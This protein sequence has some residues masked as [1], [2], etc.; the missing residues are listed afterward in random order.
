MKKKN[1]YIISGCNGAGKT[2]ASFTI[3]PEILECKEFVNAD[4]IAKGLSPFQP[5]K[6]AFEAGR[7]MLNRIDELLKSDENF[8]FETTLATKSYKQRI[9][10]AKEQGYTVTLLFFWLNNFELAKE[11]VMIR[12]N[13]GVHNIPPEV[14]ER[15]YINGIV[16][17]FDIYIDIVDQILI[18]D[19]SE[20][21]HILMA[22][23]NLEEEMLVY[24]EEKYNL[25]KQ[26][27]DS[28]RK[29]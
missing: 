7:I 29:K 1:L 15:R 26:C 28:R 16:N 13:E 24:N 23:K 4:E 19:N 14:I 2:T 21:N 10:L 22:E 18:F 3:L 5:E 8:S 9:A 17:L 11:R 12:V 20:G 25:L 27:Y 6:V